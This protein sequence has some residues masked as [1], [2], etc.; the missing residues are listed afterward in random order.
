MDLSIIIVNYRCWGKLGEC[1]HGLA[2]FIN[3]GYEFEVI[4]VDNNSDDG[5]LETFSKNYAAPFQFIQNR[6]NGGFANGCNN[7]AS[8]S[9]GR[10]LLFLNPDTIAT[11]K[12]I[13][14]LLD[15]AGGKSEKS[16][17]SC[18]QV[19]S[20]GKEKKAYGSF[21]VLGRLTGPGRSLA[22]IL[23]GKKLRPAS[24]GDVIMPDWI[25]GSV[26]MMSSNFFGML[27]GFDEDFWMYYEDMD[28]CRRARYT[29]GEI[30]Y[31]TNVSII[32]DHGGSSR[33]NT[34]TTALT[35]T[36]VKISNHLYISKHFSGIKKVLAQTLMVF[37]NLITG[38]LSA[39]IGII[40][41]F[42]P[43]FFIRTLIFSRLISYYAG[44]LYRRSWRSPLS[45]NSYRQK[46]LNSI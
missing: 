19:N 16:L 8:R 42:I 15:F 37:F 14:A 1:L 22:R 45:V 40:L 10:Y 39:A 9:K 6:F 27:G 3:P 34:K 13:K 2:V 28:I 20:G 31:L 11:Q 25:S 38:L 46:H 4:V 36:E 24:S 33:I 44:A 21:P 17:L 35:K 26:I 43:K 23:Y 30:F 5:V 29:G 41:F 32:H 7:G 12:A 18:R